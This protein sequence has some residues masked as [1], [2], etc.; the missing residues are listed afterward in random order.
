[1]TR[2]A[3]ASCGT[4]KA[5]WPQPS[6]SLASILSRLPPP[7]TVP[8]AALF[9]TSATKSCENFLYSFKAGLRPAN[10]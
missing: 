2:A 9:M 7:I 6:P 1:M 8:Q 5:T 10:S 3:R 4:Q